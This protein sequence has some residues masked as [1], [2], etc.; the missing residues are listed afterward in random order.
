MDYSEVLGRTW[1]ITWRHKWLWLLGIL[2]GC[3]SGGGGGGGG[4]FF[5]GEA[6]GQR[7]PSTGPG[8]FRDLERFIERI[9]E[10]T[11][12]AIIVAIVCLA[13]VLSLIALVLRVLGRGSLIVAFNRADAEEAI[14][15]GEVFRAGA[16]FFWRLLGLEVLVFLALVALLAVIGLLAL[17]TVIATFG[18]GLICL[19]PLLCLLI[20]LFWALGIYINFAEVALVSEDIG[21]LEALSRAWEVIRRTPG[22]VIVMALIL[23]LGSALAGLLVAA[24]LIIAAIPVAVAVAGGQEGALTTGLILAGLCVVLYLPVLLVLQGLIQT[25]VTGGWTLTYRRLRGETTG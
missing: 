9:P 10:E 8:P 23:V 1:Q 19:I 11:L 6:P 22:P 24:P 13:L 25:Y 14:S 7:G 15:L 16:S 21:V 12:I 3:G 4:N 2:A 17:G 5:Q 20:P 18:L